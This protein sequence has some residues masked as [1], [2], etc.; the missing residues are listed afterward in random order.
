[1]NDEY[2]TSPVRLGWD[3]ESFNSA[4]FELKMHSSTS[5]LKAQSSAALNQPRNKFKSKYGEF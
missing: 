4:L 1:M 2:N 5:K 3:G